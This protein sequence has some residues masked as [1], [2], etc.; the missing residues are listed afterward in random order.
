MNRQNEIFLILLSS[1]ILVVIWVCF[2][3][4]H[5]SQT[6]TLNAV[7]TGEIVPIQPTFDTKTVGEL[8]KRTVIQPIDSVTALPTPT[9]QMVYSTPLVTETP[10]QQITPSQAQSP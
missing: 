8:K 5:A 6:S 7:L 2:N 9:P 4:Y 1:F 10:S 3:I